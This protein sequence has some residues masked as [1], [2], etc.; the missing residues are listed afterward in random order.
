MPTCSEDKGQNHFVDTN[1]NYEI[2]YYRGTYT[3]GET[4]LQMAGH[5]QNSIGE[6]RFEIKVTDSLQSWLDDDNVIVNVSFPKSFEC[7]ISGRSE[8]GKTFL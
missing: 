4:A 1:N 3:N 2:V 6:P 5:D 8:C 7:V